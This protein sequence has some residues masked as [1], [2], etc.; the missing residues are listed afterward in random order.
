M[1][2]NLLRSGP[3]DDTP[4]AVPALL[5]AAGTHINGQAAVIAGELEAL[6]HRLLGLHETWTG[7]AAADYEILQQEWN[8]AAQGLFG[9]NGAPGVLGEI[10]QAMNVNWGNYSDAEFGNVQTWRSA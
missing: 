1:D 10:A 2:S 5:E 7:S 9:G 6:K 4:I 3:V 8:L